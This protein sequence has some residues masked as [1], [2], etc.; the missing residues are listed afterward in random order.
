MKA[1]IIFFYAI[2]SCVVIRAQNFDVAFYPGMKNS[3]PPLVKY[4]DAFYSY[5]T[6]MQGVSGFS[7]NL[8]RSMYNIT[9]RKYDATL[10]ETKK[11]RVNGDNKTNKRS[12]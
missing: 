10:A 5:E 9:L 3:E 11:V 4:M 1:T 12:L 6:D 2:I 8:K 7:A